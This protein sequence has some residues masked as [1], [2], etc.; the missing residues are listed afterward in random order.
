VPDSKRERQTITDCGL[1]LVRG[2]RLQRG[3]V[4]RVIES[5]CL[6]DRGSF[7]VPYFH[8]FIGM[9]AFLDWSPGGR[10]LP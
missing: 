4:E 1:A 7:L 3:L 2:V 9:F 6:H 5:K 8:D 10:L